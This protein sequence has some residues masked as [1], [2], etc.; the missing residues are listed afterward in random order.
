NAGENLVSFYRHD[1]HDYLF[2]IM[3]SED[4]F[5]DTTVL[6]DWI[7]ANISYLMP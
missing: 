7:G 4:R 3:N 5:I 1:G 2:V 6:V